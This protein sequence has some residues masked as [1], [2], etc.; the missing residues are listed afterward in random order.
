VSDIRKAV[1]HSEPES[2]EEMIRAYFMVV[3]VMLG[4]PE[5]SLGIFANLV[6]PE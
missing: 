1:K 5:E 3:G 4:L 6:P 2:V